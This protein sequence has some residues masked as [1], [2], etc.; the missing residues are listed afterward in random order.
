MSKTERAGVAR[1]LVLN[2]RAIAA[3]PPMVPVLNVR[4]ARNTAPI[5]LSSRCANN[6]A[7]TDRPPRVTFQID[8][9]SFSTAQ[10]RSVQRNASALK[11]RQKSVQYESTVQGE[12]M[13]AAINPVLV[14]P[15][16]GQHGLYN[17]PHGVFTN[18]MN[19]SVQLHIDLNENAGRDRPTK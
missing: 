8:E 17:K 19:R 3:L 10:E 18:Y 15:P 16:G 2:E 11:R 13:Q 12:Y 14:R 9:G 7:Q 5:V 6:G 4:A 1:Q